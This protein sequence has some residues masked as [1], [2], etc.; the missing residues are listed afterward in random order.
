M[1][2]A[3]MRRRIGNHRKRPPDLL[4]NLPD[5]ILCTILRLLP[6][7][8]AVR[9]SVL[10]KRWRFLWKQTSHLD[11]DVK[12]MIHPFTG[13][14]NA[15]PNSH[16]YYIL[17]LNKE[18]GVNRYG[19]LFFLILRQHLADV[20][21]CRF[22]HLPSM[23][24]D[25]WIKLL[26][27]KKKGLKDLTLECED[28]GM[29]MN[30]PFPS[31]NRFR[32]IL[33]SLRSLE[34]TY[35][36]LKT[37]YAFKSC[38]NLKTLKLE[39]MNLNDK[40]INGILANCVSLENFRLIRSDGFSKIYI[41]NS[42][43]KLLELKYLR[44]NDIE[45]YAENLQV[46]VLASVVCP[47]KNLVLVAQN[48]RVLNCCNNRHFPI[49]DPVLKYQDLLEI[50]SDLREFKRSYIFRNLSSLSIDLDLNKEREALSI[51]SILGSSVHLQTLRII[52]PVRENANLRTI[53]TSARTVEDLY[54]FLKRG[55]ISNYNG[56][57]LKFVYIE[58]FTGTELEEQFIR[59][60]ILN[61]TK[62]K[63]I[64]AV[65]YSSV[66]A[67]ELLSLRIPS[68]NFTIKLML[69]KPSSM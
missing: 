17:N 53:D 43:L 14:I 40:T 26:V 8:E 63:M 49:L 6:I 61:S 34:L 5:E 29:V 64:T 15:S 41:K 47:L 65:C 59:H 46:L 33:S 37:S 12:H 22:L 36:F 38:R 48:L 60:L 50:C 21:S 2:E 13:L 54:N 32:S 56:H 66:D 30:R 9:S 19:I 57:K 23:K 52:V 27:E 31:T 35:Y 25:T 10:S 67:Q 45:V 1:K 58:G 44:M 28:I 3:K 51:L 4:S 62:M 11:F 7:D 20:T 24:L 42:N 68:M 18:E 16:L 69:G 39:K 55:E